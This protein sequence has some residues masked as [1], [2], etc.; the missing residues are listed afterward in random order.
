MSGKVRTGDDAG[1]E[2]GVEEGKDSQDWEEDRIWGLI[3]GLGDGSLCV[4]T[5]TGILEGNGL[6]LLVRLLLGLQIIV[7]GGKR[8]GR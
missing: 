2:Y 7:K 5:D 6:L 1:L 4:L 8:E 3:S